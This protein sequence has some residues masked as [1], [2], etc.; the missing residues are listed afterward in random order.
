MHFQRKTDATFGKD[1]QNG[2]E[3]L[4]EQRKSLV[5]HFGGDGWKRI[6]QRPDAGPRKSIDNGNPQLLRGTRGVFKFFCRAQI[7]AVRLAVAPYMRWQDRAVPLI[8]HVQDR[9]AHQVRADGVQLQIVPIQQI[10]PLG[11]VPVIADRLIDFKMIAPAGQLQPL[12]AKVG[13]LARQISQLQICPLAS[14]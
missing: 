3:T 9:L 4:C 7:D 11:A 5:D 12:I 10:Q 1:V 8:N 6:E 13:G 14:E 2:M